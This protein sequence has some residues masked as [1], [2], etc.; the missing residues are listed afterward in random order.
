MFA[1][2]QL[3]QKDFIDTKDLTKSF[4]WTGAEAFQQQDIQEFMRVLFDALEQSHE[5][6]GESCETKKLYE[7]SCSSYIL[8]KRC[9]NESSRSETFLDIQRPIRNE[10]GVGVINSSL[11]MALE[12]YLKPEMLEGDN[13]YACEPCDCKVD[14][15]KGL[16]LERCP[17]LLVLNFNRFMLDYETFQRVK[18]TERVSFPMVLNLNAYMRGYE[19]I[20]NKLYEKEVELVQNLDH[21]AVAANL[22]VE[23]KKDKALHEM[24]V[25]SSARKQKTKVPTWFGVAINLGTEPSEKV[26]KPAAKNGVH[27]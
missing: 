27:I 18:V 7:G 19:G 20:E 12:N 13:Q 1:Q 2:L 6:A 14:A 25:N 9:S 10:F 5:L 11:E 26:S 24:R 23:S 21:K 22:Q 16:K 17:P 15:E 3:S 8:C 4:G